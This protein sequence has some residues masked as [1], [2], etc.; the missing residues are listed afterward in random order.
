MFLT[1]SEEAQQQEVISEVEL[2]AGAVGEGHSLWVR[3][4]ERRESGSS[5][6]QE[7]QWHLG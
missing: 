6:F 7:E 4:A 5:S 1:R 3:A 2:V